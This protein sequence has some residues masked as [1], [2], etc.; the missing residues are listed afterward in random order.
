MAEAPRPVRLSFLT[1]KNQTYTKSGPQLR[2]RHRAGDPRKR[3]PGV[4]PAYTVDRRLQPVRNTFSNLEIRL[5]PLRRRTA[6]ATWSDSD[7]V[8]PARAGD[9]LCNASAR[10]FP[11]GR[12]FV[13][14]ACAGDRRLKPARSPARLHPPP[15]EIG[16]CSEKCATG[17]TFSVSVALPYTGDRRLQPGRT[18]HRFPSLPGPLLYPR[19][20]NPCS[21][22]DLIFTL[23]G[24]VEVARPPGKSDAVV[25]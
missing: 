25:V 7:Q 23:E 8:A 3:L 15:V 6:S 2:S 11:N 9:R 21:R 13:A 16:L 17:R 22:S 20:S 18:P 12:K 4:A 10:H 24:V 5:H 19:E 14:P 1:S